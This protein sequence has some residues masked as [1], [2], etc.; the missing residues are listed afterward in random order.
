MVPEYDQIAF[1]PCFLFKLVVCH[2]YVFTSP[3]RRV[4][5]ISRAWDY[6]VAAQYAEASVLAHTAHSRENAYPVFDKERFIGLRQCLFDGYPPVNESGS[7]L[8]VSFALHSHIF[9]VRIAFLGILSGRFFD[10]SHARSVFFIV[11]RY[12]PVGPQRQTGRP[13]DRFAHHRAGFFKRIGLFGRHL[14]YHF[15][16]YV[17]HDVVP[18]FI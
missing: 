15:V 13:D 12:I 9:R 6:F 8:K 17:H 1:S 7:R 3:L 4:L 18:H 16:M 5:P 14:Q 10:S 11:R 2:C